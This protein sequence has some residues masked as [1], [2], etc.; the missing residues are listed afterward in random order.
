MIDVLE[1]S[2]CHVVITPFLVRSHSLRL[3][4]EQWCRERVDLFNSFCLPS[5]AS[6]T[7]GAFDWLIFIDYESPDWLKRYLRSLNG[8]A[9]ESIIEIGGALSS[10]EVRQ[11]LGRRQSAGHLLTS[12]LDNDDALGRSFVHT[13]QTAARAELGSRVCFNFD[14]GLQTSRFGTTELTDLSNP[15]VSLLEPWGPS[16]A[17]VVGL[18]H[19]EITKSFRTIHIQ[20]PPAW[21]QVIHGGNLGNFLRSARPIESV[22]QGNFDVTKDLHG[23]SILGRLQITC[24]RLLR[25]AQL[26]SRR[27]VR[28]LWKELPAR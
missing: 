6:Q 28:M 15:F 25:V 27:V 23:P 20:G 10:S 1:S 24:L 2:I 21:M 26:R 9:H 7:C 16:P 11:A 12:R 17:T 4:S 3:P 18:S 14:N 22:H 19:H 5:V 13:L 8:V